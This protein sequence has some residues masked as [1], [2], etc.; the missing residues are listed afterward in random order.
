MEPTYFTPTKQPISMKPIAIN[1]ISQER[2][3]DTVNIREEID[4]TD[5][6][7]D[8]IVYSIYALDDKEKQVIKDF[9]A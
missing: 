2:I 6:A 8:E 9:L 7:I 3:S 4:K 1:R 5:A